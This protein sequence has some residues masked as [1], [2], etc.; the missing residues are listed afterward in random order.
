MKI[1]KTDFIDIEEK[2]YLIRGEKVMLDWDLADLYG[3]STM[4]LNE[5]VR[6]NLRRFPPDFMFQLSNQEFK[7]LIS[8]IAISKSG[9]G[10]RRK[11]PLVFTEQGVAML[12]AVLHSERAI[13]VNIAVMRAFVRLR[14]VLNSNHEFEKRITELE[15]KYDGQFEVVFEA[16]R[17]L[18]SIHSVPSKRIIALAPESES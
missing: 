1:N 10:G 4:R 9:R 2:I 7:A 3:V 13:D 17:E 5:Q 14:Q 15:S 18:M 8:Q 16:I 12:S 6:R 11:A